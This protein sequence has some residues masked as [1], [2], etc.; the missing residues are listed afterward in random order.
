[1]TSGNAGDLVVAGTSQSDSTHDITGLL[2]II[3]III[4]SSFLHQPLAEND[5]NH[6]KRMSHNGA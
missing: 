1:M 6:P 3:I 5:E 4:T 2:L